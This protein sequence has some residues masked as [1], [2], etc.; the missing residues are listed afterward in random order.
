M[1]LYN[2]R[3]NNSWG[4]LSMDYKTNKKL[5]SLRFPQLMLSAFLITIAIALLIFAPPVGILIL[6]PWATF[7]VVG[8][9]RR[10]KQLRALDAVLAEEASSTLA[11]A[12]DRFGLD[13]GVNFSIDP[14]VAYGF[15]LEGIQ[16]NQI[17]R[18]KKMGTWRTS[19]GEVVV[20]LFSDDLLHAFKRTFS[21]VDP[22]YKSE[23]T[24]EFFYKD[25]VSISTISKVDE[26]FEHELFILT[27][28]GGT[29]VTC[30]LKRTDDVERSLQA[31]K[32]TI[33]EKKS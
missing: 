9:K 3:L 13:E 12:L 23:I 10:L 27:T 14:L 21:F 7:T 11:L 30:V 33:R 4:T 25:V 15:S 20:M 17:K 31:A 6:G 24:D 5:F 18:D 26:K 16:L 29:S 8:S 32:K 1:G 22:K 28:T 19:R 2:Q